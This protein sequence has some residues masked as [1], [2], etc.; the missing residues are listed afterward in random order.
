MTGLAGVGWPKTGVRLSA[1]RLAARQMD[2]FINWLLAVFALYR[3]TTANAKSFAARREI[4]LL[5][6]KPRLTPEKHGLITPKPRPRPAE[7]RL[8]SSKHRLA[9][10]KHRL[11]LPEHGLTLSGQRLTTAEHRLESPNTRLNREIWVKQAFLPV[12]RR[13]ATVPAR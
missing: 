2:F 1:S 11:T 13:M 10:P 3:N 12:P 6:P 9:L 7:H 8:G 5:F 4:P